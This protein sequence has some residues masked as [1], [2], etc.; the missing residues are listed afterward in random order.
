MSSLLRRQFGPGHSVSRCLAPFLGFLLFVFGPLKLLASLSQ[1]LLGRA[2]RWR[3]WAC[4][5]RVGCSDASASACSARC[6]RSR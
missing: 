2:H 1:L 3:A 4:R 6:L 5:S